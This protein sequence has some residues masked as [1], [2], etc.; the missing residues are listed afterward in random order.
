M[1]GFVGVVRRPGAPAP[2]PE[3]L[4]TLAAHLAHRGPDAAGRCEAG[5]FALAATRLAVQGDR[6][7]DP[8]LRSRDGRWLVAFNGEILGRRQEGLRRLVH[9]A[10]MTPP[11][12][13]AG[14]APLLVEAIAAV[15]GGP[16]GLQGPLL[17]ELLESSMGAV[18][19]LD[20]ERGEA[21]L[22]RDRLGIKP[23]YV[24]AR[25]DETLFASEI[26]P[27]LR[28]APE[29]RAVDPDGLAELV[30]F[31]RPVR[32][33]PFRH[34]ESLP[35]G[36]CWRIASGGRITRWVGGT[37]IRD[38]QPAEG[39]PEEEVATALDALLDAVSTS[40]AE[41]AAVDGPVSMFLSGGLDSAAV[42]V[43]CARPGVR[44]ITG[45]FDPRG[46]PFDESCA[47]SHVAE[48]AGLAHEVLPL[49]DADLVGDLPDVVRAL[50]IPMAGPGALPL[51]RLVRRAREIGR[52]VLTG[53]G[54]DELLGGYGRTALALGRAGPWTA[55]YE[56]LAAR[57]DA[58]GLDLAA[59]Q[60]AVLDR[61]ADLLPLLAAS[62]RASLPVVEPPGSVVRHGAPAGRAV[63]EL[64]AEEVEGTLPM[65]LHVEDRITMAHGLEGRP[66]PCLGGVPRAAARL[67]A[68]WLVG[69]D[70]E[71][72][73]ALRHVLRGRVP[74]AVRLDPVKRGFP[75][76]F[77]RAARG[78]GRA[79][80]EGV[81]GDR[82]FVERGWWDVAACRRALDAPRPD[83]DRALYALL[84]WE[85]WAR[86]YLDGDALQPEPTA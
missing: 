54:G 80:V 47:A 5:A 50:E 62:F 26:R 9:A 19:A 69:P 58:A 1:C 20:R 72:K 84:S 44:A 61:S 85:F 28:A 36:A 68:S 53:T 40:A 16:E 70:G 71:T 60:R 64:V 39:E 76:P 4:A 27:L 48:T 22:A 67:P 33:L 45:R 12:A 86:A 38:L 66:V 18:A 23:L 32:T 11:D 78:A 73:R 75:T 42:A 37:G 6:R 46:G 43:S 3:R 35:P 7:A 30:H 17:L 81:L 13:E 31:H 52:V 57:L 2:A 24:L 25:R 55:G 83:H 49:R 15:A 51:W 21:W 63:R 59:R 10:G 82:R 74:D 77:A 65:L 79:A 29:A 34:V 8:P 14:D 56:P 41:A